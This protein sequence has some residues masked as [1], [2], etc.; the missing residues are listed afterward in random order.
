MILRDIKPAP[1]GNIPGSPENIRLMD[2]RPLSVF[3]TPQ[4]LITKAS[5]PV[6]DMHAHAWELTTDL[7]KWIARMDA[8]NIEKAIILSFETGETFDNII[9]QYAPYKNRFSVW[10]GFDY[11]GYNSGD[12]SWT[13]KAITELERCRKK[14]AQGVGELGDKGLGEYYSSPVPGYGMH[15]DDPRMDPLFEACARLHMPVSAHVADPI[16]MYLPMDETNDG[17]MNAYNWRIEMKEGMLNHSQLID[18]FEH[19]VQKH[20]NTT[21]IACHFANCTH[22]LK[23]I[24]AMLDKYPNLYTDITSRLKEICT[25]PRYAKAFFEMYAD[26]LLFGSDLGYDPSKTMDFTTQLYETTFRLLETADEHI[27]SHNLFRYH[28]P[29]YGLQL[30]DEILMKLYR[31][32]AEKVMNSR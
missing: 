8:A 17:M 21:F 2:Y 22:D 23:V 1:L 7:S 5:Y 9:K 26:R 28:W 11:T 30:D 20:P 14:G 3:N 15:F 18:S 6:I 19:A 12:K 29:L 27:Y 4:T 10:C 24:A 32:N 16:W 25:V 13:D 31:R